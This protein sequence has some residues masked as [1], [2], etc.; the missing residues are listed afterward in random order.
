MPVEEITCNSNMLIRFLDCCNLILRAFGKHDNTG[1]LVGW[2]EGGKGD[3]PSDNE[4]A[5]D[6][7]VGISDD[8]GA[9]DKEGAHPS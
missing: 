1:D 5:G 3:G 4:G 7:G 8:E 9:G 6:N 2:S